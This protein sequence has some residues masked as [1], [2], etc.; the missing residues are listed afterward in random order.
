MC[1]NQLGRLV[2]KGRDRYGSYFVG[3]KIRGDGDEDA[4]LFVTGLFNTTSNTRVD[5]GDVANSVMDTVTDESTGGDECYGCDD[6]TYGLLNVETKLAQVERYTTVMGRELGEKENLEEKPSY[7]ERYPL[8]QASPEQVKS[9]DSDKSQVNSNVAKKPSQSVT[10]EENKGLKVG[11]KVRYVGKKYRES[12]G[13]QVME[14]VKI[15]VH[16]TG[17]Q[18][19]CKYTKGWTTWLAESSLEKVKQDKDGKWRVSE[20]YIK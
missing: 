8:G 1:L 19:T 6:K 18:V 13:N 7:A 16:W 5:I 12:I 17:N 4:P 15:S 20:S 3:L 11:D 14:V 2:E 9:T 10:K